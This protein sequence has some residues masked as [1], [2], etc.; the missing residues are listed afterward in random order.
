MKEMLAMM[1]VEHHPKES[2]KNIKPIAEEISIIYL[3]WLI[4]NF[5]MII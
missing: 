1:S 2:Y 5:K 3:K 4:I